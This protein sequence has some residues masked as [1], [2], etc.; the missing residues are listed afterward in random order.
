MRRYLRRRYTL[1]S[2]LQQTGNLDL[3]VWHKKGT[4][5]KQEFGNYIA[6][7]KFRKLYIFGTKA[8]HIQ[9]FYIIDKR[10]SNT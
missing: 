2:D 1:H 5:A 4:D 9:S 10:S 7:I 3:S 8:M 6:A